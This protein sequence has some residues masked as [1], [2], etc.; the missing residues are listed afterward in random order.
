[1]SQDAKDTAQGAGGQP[2][3]R[4][5]AEPGA[6]MPFEHKIREI[7]DKIHELKELAGTTSFDV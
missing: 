7:E 4:R 2:A 6:A 1:M 5:N 3:P